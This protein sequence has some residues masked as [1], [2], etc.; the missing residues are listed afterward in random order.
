MS[1]ASIDQARV[2]GATG[3]DRD[4]QAALDA[5]RT[6]V[7]R[8]TGD[9]FAPTQ[10]TV[11]ARVSGD[12]TALLPY[13]VQS[14]DRVRMV[15]VNYDLQPDAYLVLSSAL[16]GQIDAV[17]LGGGASSGN[18]LVLGAEPWNGGWQNLTRTTTGQCE[19]TGTFGHSV[20]PPAV[21]DAAAALAAA[22][23]QG[24]LLVPVVGA[25]STDDEGNAVS[26]TVDATQPVRRTPTTGVDSVDALLMPYVRESVTVS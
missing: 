4:V 25:V 18:M 19:V 23:T 13:R 5:A 8:F 15:G 3:T 9:L 12:G 26:I 22:R 16:P 24:Q 6:L 17:L 10:L 20:V 21:A 1:Y 7:E 2:A 14:V 11:V